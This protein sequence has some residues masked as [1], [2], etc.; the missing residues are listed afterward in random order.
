MT[1]YQ[2]V[3]KRDFGKYGYWNSE[4]RR[5]EFVGFV[6]TDGFCNIIPG[7]CWFRTEEEAKIGIEAHKITGDTFAWHAEYKRLAAEAKAIADARAFE[8]QVSI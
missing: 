5:N 8:T 2:I 1:N 7:A 6:V 4:T 3:P